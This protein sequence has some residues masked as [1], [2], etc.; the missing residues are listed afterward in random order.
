MV[1]ALYKIS[2]D[3]FLQICVAESFI[4][5]HEGLSLSVKGI[6]SS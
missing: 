1:R 5:M 4:D 6:E 3:R 2:D